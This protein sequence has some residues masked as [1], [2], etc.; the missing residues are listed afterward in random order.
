MKKQ[1]LIISC[2]V[3]ALFAISCR[4]HYQ[5]A[6]IQGSRIVIDKTYDAMP[7][8]QA[9]AFI[10]PYQHQVDSI[11]S[12]VVGTCA[13]YMA[14]KRPESTLSN[15]LADILV[16]GAKKY[17]E[18]PNLA[19]YNMGGIRAAFAEG[20]VNY[21]QVIDVA[22][23]E[24]KICFLSMT[25]ENLLKLFDQVAARHGE[26]LSHGAELVISKDGKLISARLHGKEIDPKETYRIATLDYLAQGNDGL[27]AF[28]LATNLV[29]P[30]EERNNVR[31]II[32][33]YF[34]EQMKQ[35]K[36]VDAQVE[37]RIVEK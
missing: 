6:S 30:K 3:G 29:S 4:S 17:N 27:S 22:P 13:R 35:G 18:S 11:M 34:R 24:N 15:L 2:A 14:A 21:G 32:I 28:K 5:V 23:F 36:A 37:G 9:A 26:G 25:G 8:A 31:F 16:W 33:D 7:D 19:V 10:K 20:K 1:L 12:P